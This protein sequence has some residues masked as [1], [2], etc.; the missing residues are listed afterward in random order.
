MFDFFSSIYVVIDGLVCTVYRKL[1]G[2]GAA[3]Q[4]HVFS[5]IR[6]PC[7]SG[8]PGK[9]LSSS[10]VMENTWQNV[11]ENDLSISCQNS[12]KQV[13]VTAGLRDVNDHIN[14]QMVTCVYGRGNLACAPSSPA[15][16]KSSYIMLQM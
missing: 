10:P 13:T 4:S 15:G 7:V 11:L 14:I 5:W 12:P 1:V 2:C 16:S 9:Q 6:V 3:D 8:K